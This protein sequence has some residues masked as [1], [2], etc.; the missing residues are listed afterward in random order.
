[1]SFVDYPSKSWLELV[2]NCDSHARGL[3][4]ELVRYQSDDRLGAEGV[5]LRNLE[6]VIRNC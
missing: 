4:A 6:M 1:M 3:V 2:P 5:S